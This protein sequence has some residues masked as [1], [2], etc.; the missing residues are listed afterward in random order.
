L[1]IVKIPEVTHLE[2]ALATHL[3]D[4][5]MFG[6]RDLGRRS[7]VEANRLVHVEAGE[8]RV[9]TEFGSKSPSLCSSTSAITTFAP[10]ATKPRA[11][12]A[13]IP[14]APPVTTTVR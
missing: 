12:L 9:I 10:S 3:D 14:R 6:V 13:P 4:G 1:R 7:N 8:D 5:Q 2:D 11:W